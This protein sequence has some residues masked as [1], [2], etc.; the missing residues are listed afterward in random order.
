VSNVFCPHYLPYNSVAE[1]LTQQAADTLGLSLSGKSGQ[2]HQIIIAS[3][4]HAVKQRADDT[5]V[6]RTG[7]DNK[8]SDAGSFLGSIT[9]SRMAY[10]LESVNKIWD[11]LRCRGD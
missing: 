2:K 11:F 3:F 6:W 9:G 10:I 1:R 8:D 5:I 4:L 7:K